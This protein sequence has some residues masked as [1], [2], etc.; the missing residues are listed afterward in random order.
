MMGH[1]TEET[2][3]RG[4]AKQTAALVLKVPKGERQWRKLP[5]NTDC[6]LTK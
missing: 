5:G 1:H 4:M 2:I 3:E 6:S